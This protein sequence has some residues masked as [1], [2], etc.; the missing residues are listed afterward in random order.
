[1]NAILTYL[2]TN[3]RYWVPPIVLFVTLLVYLASNSA[4]T[5]VDPFE[6]RFD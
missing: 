6:Y 5:P 2:A 1:M 4:A 3:K